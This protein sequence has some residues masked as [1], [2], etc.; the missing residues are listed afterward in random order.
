MKGRIFVAVLLV[1]AAALAGRWMNRAVAPRAAGTREETRQTFRLDAGARVEVSAINGKVEIKTGETDTAEVHILRTADSPE[2]L[3]YNRVTVEAEPSSLV[4][5][6]ER[7]GGGG[8][9][10]WLSGGRGHSRQEVTLTLPRRVE[11]SASHV[12]GALSVGEVDG[13]VEVTHVN[14]RV[15]VAQASG[16]S[17]VSHVNG[18]VRVGVSRL[19]DEGMEVSHVNGNIEVRFREAVN[20]DVE[21]ERQ[22]GGLSVNV[23]NVTMK[24]RLSRSHSRLR[25]GTGGVPVRIS[26]VNG[27]IRFESDAAGAAQ[28]APAFTLG[29]D[30]PE[31]EMP[32]PPPPPAAPPAPPAPP[33][34]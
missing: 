9:W 1:A 28:A 11:V 26:H 15:E 14:G 4:V 3:E 12:N 32:P 33:A 19:G 6:G 18:G 29:A 17:E 31:V 24:E 30:A 21:V 20:A 7:G 13:E 34:P 27:S 23:S 16:R 10:R 22:N 2:A 25:F 5:R 8:F